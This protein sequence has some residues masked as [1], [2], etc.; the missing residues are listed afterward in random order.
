M[1]NGFTTR[2]LTLA[3]FFVAVCLSLLPWAWT[4]RNAIAAPDDVTVKDAGTYRLLSGERLFAK[5]IFVGTVCLWDLPV[6]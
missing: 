1:R 2:A 5:K 3:G 4:T 6:R